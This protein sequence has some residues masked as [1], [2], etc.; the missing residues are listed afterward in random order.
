MT[1]PHNIHQL[2]TIFAD[3]ETGSLACLE[4]VHIQETLWL[5]DELDELHR[6][7]DGL[8]IPRFNP[9]EG[10]DL[11]LTARLNIALDMPPED[12]E[13]EEPDK[14]QHLTQGT[15]FERPSRYTPQHQ[16]IEIRL[17]L[18]GDDRPWTEIPP[19]DTTLLCANIMEAARLTRIY[20]RQSVEQDW[21]EARWNWKGGLQGHLI[22]KEG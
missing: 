1:T 17:R 6:L 5:L 4:P 18:K 16:P 21:I 11:D 7:L 8:D 9:A 3:L 14:P 12:Q 2:Q 13:Q 22:Q 20:L 15:L 19:E 10:I